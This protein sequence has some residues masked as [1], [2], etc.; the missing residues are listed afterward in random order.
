M[1]ITGGALKGRRLHAP[2]SAAIRP[3]RDQV[4]AALFNILDDLVSGSHF[5]DLFAGTGSVGLEAL[6]R[7]AVRAVF[8][9][10]S[11]EAVQIIERNVLALGLRDR[12]TILQ[13]DVFRALERLWR[14]G[15]RF[16]LVFIGPPYRQNLAHHTLERLGELDLLSER[17][18]VA[19]E[20]FKKEHVEPR[21]GRLALFDERVYG[22][23]L[24][25]LYRWEE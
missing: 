15:E 13:D 21:Y 19:T 10:S 16:D 24:I 2:K 5:L 3:M 20:I 4:R 7:G 11:R 12:V 6:S 9:D 8:V 17:A 25:V 22:D 1:R 18:I 23:N 14:R